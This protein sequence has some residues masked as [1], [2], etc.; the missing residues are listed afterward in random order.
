MIRYIVKD[1]DVIVIADG[2][3]AHFDPSQESAYTTEYLVWLAEGN[4]PEPWSPDAD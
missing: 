2:W 1:V 3:S 4:T